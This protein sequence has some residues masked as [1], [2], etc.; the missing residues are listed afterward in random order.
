MLVKVKFIKKSLFGVKG[1]ERL[2]T[3]RAARQYHALD[4]IEP[5]EE[6]EE[7]APVETKEEKQVIET[8]EV[9]VT[10]AP[11]E[12]VKATVIATVKA[13]DLKKTV[14]KAPDKKKGKKK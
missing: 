13:D 2:V 6:K 10:T 8:K 9:K 14:A 5:F 12:E 1:E 7:K 4:L 11:K 3:D